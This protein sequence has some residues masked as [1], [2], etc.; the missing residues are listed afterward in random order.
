MLSLEGGTTLDS[1]AANKSGGS[2]YSASGGS[3]KMDT[4]VRIDFAPRSGAPAITVIAGGALTFGTKTTLRC[5]AGEQLMY[6]ISTLQS[7][8]DEWVIDCNQVQTANNGTAITYTNPTCEPLQD[9]PSP[10][11]T[12]GCS[13]LPLKPLMLMT[14]GTATC[15]PCSGSLYSLDRGEKHGNAM[16]IAITC[17]ECPFGGDCTEGGADLKVTTG[18]WGYATPSGPVGGG[19]NQSV[20]SSVDSRIVNE[21]TFGTQ[22]TV[23]VCPAGYCC[24]QDVAPCFWDS[25]TA[26]PGNRDHIHPLCGGCKQNYSQAIDGSNCVPDE[27]CGKGVGLYVTMQLVYW[28]AYDMYALF[29]A[30]HPALLRILPRRMRPSARNS[31]HVAVVIYFFQMAAVSVPQGYRT[32]VNRAL[33][34][35]GDFSQLRQ[36]STGQGSVCVVREMTMV[37]R[38]VWRLLEPLVL[39]L[40]LPLVLGA[41]QGQNY[42]KRIISGCISNGRDRGSLDSQ[43]LGSLQEPM[44]TDVTRE[45]S[46]AEYDAG[47]PMI[48]QLEEMVSGDS[49]YL[50]GCFDER[51]N[52]S[53]STRGSSRGSSLDHSFSR[54]SFSGLALAND[55]NAANAFACLLLFGFTGVVESTMQLLDC[56]HIGGVDVLRFAGETRC[57]AN[58]QWLLWL[59]LMALALLPAVVVTAWLLCQLPAKGCG[60]QLGAWVRLRSWPQGQLML[61]AMRQHPTEPFVDSCWHWTLLLCVKR[62]LLVMCH[63]LATEDVYTSVG[64]ALVSL[65]FLLIQLLGRPYREQRTNELQTVAVIC[66]LLL[67]TLEIASSAFRSAGFDVHKAAAGLATLSHDSAWVMF[68]LLFPTPLLCI[69]GLARKRLQD[70]DKGG[71][72]ASGGDGDVA[73]KRRHEQEKAQLLQEKQQLAHEKQQLA[74]EKQQERQRHKQEKQQ[75]ALEKQQLAQEKQQLAQE[76][77]QERQR[78]NKQEKAQLQQEKQQL[79]QEK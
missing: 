68:L 66:L 43:E 40:L 64:A 37:H 16:P 60:S 69:F 75:L 62:L 7:T 30:R 31:G 35:L 18:F 23:L 26:C 1:N 44:L 51:S 24:A 71:A 29:A 57:G 3:I 25:E 10:L 79:A 38:L 45:S 8:F 34:S 59:V 20:Q 21:R 22:L 77:E 47:E 74:Q 54:L 49:E 2:I 13:G 11:Q 70:G 27:E 32:L 58:W 41:L 33:Q 42:L 46:E 67:C 73:E 61:A 17:L 9:G 53:R 72:D 15:I 14:T 63:A 48:D 4:R 19:H 76:K 65:I 78:H 56:A 50:D 39:L 36:L 52:T 6:N 5:A 55:P 28:V 12:L